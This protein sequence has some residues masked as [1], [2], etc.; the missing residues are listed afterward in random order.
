M[1]A[2]VGVIAGLLV[3]PI[4]IVLLLG[5]DGAC[6]PSGATATGGVVPV[7]GLNEGVV[8]TL[9]G[10]SSAPK[11]RSEQVA[12]AATIVA[13]GAK[14]GMP[15]KGQTIGVAVAMGESSLINVGFGDDRFGVTNPDGSPTCSL[16]LFQQQWC[17]GSTWG[18]KEQVMDPRHA[19]G[20]FF[21]AL[22]Q[23]EG[24]QDLPPT[25]AAHRTQRNAD[26]YHYEKY[27]D[28]AVVLTSALTG[29]E[30]ADLESAA[31]AAGACVV[32]AAA[33]TGKAGGAIAK[34]GPAPWGGYSNG[35]IP[36][37]ALAP[38]PWAPG[39]AA[40]SD[41]VQALTGLNALFRQ[42]FGRD[43]SITDS[44]RSYEQQVATK[45]AKGYLAATPGYSNHGWALALD[46]GGGINDFGTA[47]YE[48]MKAHAP[49]FGWVHPQWAEPGGRKP[50][51]WHWEFVGGGADAQ[52]A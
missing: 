24:W 7:A 34:N 10:L 18:T 2:A 13:V 3:I 49:A 25:I 43:L 51:P 14:K 37:P 21:D 47:E 20:A 36:E 44:Y 30:L 5:D 4:V 31:P 16:G 32:D 33:G 17:L 15:I 19:A 11:E 27:W 9:P 48:W 52:G 29:V 40:R 42:Q 41:A 35:R 38:I 46:L 12:N 6:D 39:E 23:V 22:A 28:A 1:K 26:P 45:A 8:A 50:E